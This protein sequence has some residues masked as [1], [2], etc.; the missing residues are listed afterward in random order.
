MQFLTA[1][2]SH[3]E[4]LSCIISDYPSGVSVD[5]AFINNELSRRQKG[6]GRGSRMSIE[7]DNVKILSGVQKGKSTGSPVS[8]LI[9]NHDWQNWKDKVEKEGNLLNPRPGHADL[10]GILK[11]RLESIREVIERS[12]ARETAARTAAGA[13]AKLI[14]TSLDIFIISYVNRIGDIKLTRKVNIGNRFNPNVNPEDRTLVE[15]IEDSNLRCP[16]DKISSLMSDLI[17][18]A[19]SQGDTLGGAFR[20]IA[21]GIVPGLGSYIQWDRR[22]DSKIAASLFSIPSVKAVGFGKILSS[23][24]LRGTGYHDEIFYNKRSGFYR[25][26]NNA[27]GIE[28]GM[29][30]GEAIDIEVFLKPIPTTKTGLKTVNI[31]T[32]EKTISLK[33]RADVCAVPSA[34][35][36]GEAVLAVE[37]LNAIQEKFGKDNIEEIKENLKNYKGYLNSI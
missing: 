14:L 7:K 15:K 16:N 12:S 4:A 11:Y 2:E 23:K 33:E 36:I 29:T 1:G 8:F 20:L 22:I 19:S 31:K 27:G 3:G 26:S 30:N 10:S 25:K 34:A 9:Y 28:G 13:F 18:K 24:N 32:K 5:I 6:F 35:V 21:T 17:K 37:L